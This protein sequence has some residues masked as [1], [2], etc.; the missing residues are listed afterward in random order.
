MWIRSQDEITLVTVNHVEV[1]GT[2]IVCNKWTL[3]EYETSA[4]AKQVISLIHQHLNDYAY[5]MAIGAG[6]CN[7][8]RMPEE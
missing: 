6:P 1:V 3:G 4:R 7:V 5:N 2:R 8:F